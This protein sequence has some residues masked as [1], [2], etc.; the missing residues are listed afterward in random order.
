MARASRTVVLGLPVALYLVS[1]VL[2]MYDS[3]SGSPK[4]TFGNDV[5]LDGF[6]GFNRWSY[7]HWKSR[8][9][10][11]AWL[12]NPT[13]WTTF[14]WLAIG[15]RGGTIVTSVIA[16]LLCACMLPDWSSEVVWWPSYWCWSGSAFA[17]LLTGL[18][19]LEGPEPEHADDSA[20]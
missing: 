16:G 7:L 20:H 15:Y 1:F 14:V 13:M 8:Q 5:F 12:A 10:T 11:V 3:F 2:P 19:V 4:L 6:E 9:I 18:F 17:A